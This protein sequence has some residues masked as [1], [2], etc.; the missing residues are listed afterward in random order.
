MRLSDKHTCPECTQECKTVADFIPAAN[1]AA[2]VLGV[3][4]NQ[5]VP[6]LAAPAA[7]EEQQDLEEPDDPMDVDNGNQPANGTHSLCI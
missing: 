5:E 6:Q 1:D 3:D 2:A 4:E 7:T